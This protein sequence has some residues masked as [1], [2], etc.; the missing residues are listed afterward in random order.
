[1]AYA[2]APTAPSEPS[3][4]RFTRKAYRQMTAL[5]LFVGKRAELI[6]GE[7]IEMSLMSP[8]H[9]ASG[10]DL[11]SLLRLA[12]PKGYWARFQGSLSRSESE[13]EPDISV[14]RGDPDDYP[15]VHPDAALLGV[16]IAD[17]SLHYDRTDKQSLYAKAG[18]PE[19]WIVNLREKQLEVY[20]APAPDPT[21]RFGYA[22]HQQ[23]I[24][25]PRERVQLV[26]IPEV[27]LSV[28]RILRAALRR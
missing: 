17:T 16:E 28:R 6:E 2:I 22:Y 21:A 14:V 20:R 19:Y 10:D 13:P 7:A 5:G 12:L 4:F 26:A 11:H 15:D 27:S 18:I 25:T 8:L 1:M 24:L 23:Q 3:R 9:F